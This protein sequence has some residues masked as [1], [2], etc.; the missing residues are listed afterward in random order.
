MILAEDL[1]SADEALQIA[2]RLNLVLEAP[3]VLPD[4]EVGVSASVGIAFSED[5]DA[6]GLLVAADVAL[7]R[8]KAAGRNAVA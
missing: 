5:H 2:E 8:A 3:I 1:E 6:E 7:Y 4:H